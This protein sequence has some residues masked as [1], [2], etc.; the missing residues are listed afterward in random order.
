MVTD[1]RSHGGRPY[2]PT[3]CC[4]GAPWVVFGWS[5]ARCLVVLL[6]RP[7][8]LV[9]C[10]LCR[11]V[12]A[13]SPSEFHPFVWSFIRSLFRFCARNP[14]KY[15]FDTAICLLFHSLMGFASVSLAFGH[16]FLHTV[17]LVEYPR[18]L[19]NRRC[20]HYGPGV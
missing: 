6:G 18:G 11:W 5:C 17:R 7:E 1:S 16:I 3:L 12:W 9:E 15:G 20:S 14:P 10:S 19:R 8:R 2:Y 13:L 4:S